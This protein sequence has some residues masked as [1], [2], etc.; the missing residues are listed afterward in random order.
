M[1]E[2]NSLWMGDISPDADESVILQYFRHYNIYPIS[3]KFIKDKKTNINR[4]YCF[5]YFKNSED[6]N[7]ALNQLNGKIIPNTKIAFKLNRAS[8]HSPINRTIYVG[9]LSKSINDDMLLKLF[10]KKYNSVNK[11]TIIR[12]NG[13]SKGYGF[14]VFKKENEY[15]KCLNEMDGAVISGKNIVVREQKRKD[16]D[17]S[18]NNNDNINSK[19][20]NNIIINNNINNNN[21]YNSEYNNANNNINNDIVLKYILRNN[22]I[23]NNFSYL[24]N[25]NKLNNAGIINKDFHNNNISN[26]H[27]IY[28]NNIGKEIF[29]NQIIDLLNNNNNYENI[30]NL[31]NKKVLENNFNS[32]INTNV[33]RNINN[34]YNIISN[35]E[36]KNIDLANLLKKENN[37]NDN[38]IRNY[39]QK[40]N[41]NNN[42]SFF[43]NNNSKNNIISN[44]GKINLNNNNLLY[45]NINKNDEN[46]KKKN[47]KKN[48]LIKLEILEKYDEKTLIKKIRDSINN[49]F[50]FYK[51][52]FLSNG[53]DC[54]CKY[55]YK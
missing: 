42:N 45:S 41:N 1:N 27:N 17:G 20:N 34:Y 55:I 51:D 21:E 22:G 18:N 53:S 47:S 13:V 49:T 28:N 2:E 9:N 36:K 7:K 16:D 5:V 19:T 50:S 26:S 48:T 6:T 25:I 35:I 4:N 23:I 54:K 44:I 46:I 24:N 32:N 11:A 15:K 39:N 30:N 3:I 12:E 38:L 14:V 40:M 8:Y 43:L 29:N 10:Q 33:N 37:N 31:Y 52:F